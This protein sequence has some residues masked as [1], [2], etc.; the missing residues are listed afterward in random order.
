MSIAVRCREI[1]TSNGTIWLGSVLDGPVSNPGRSK[2]ET[3]LQNA[4]AG[5]GAQPATY[6]LGTGVPSWG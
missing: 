1:E 3:L 5:S 2:I 4:Q 6:S